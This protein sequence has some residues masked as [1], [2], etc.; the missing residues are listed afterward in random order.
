[1][2][3]VVYHYRPIGMSGWAIVLII[4]AFLVGAVYYVRNRMRHAP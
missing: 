3:D 4:A 1:M 2:D